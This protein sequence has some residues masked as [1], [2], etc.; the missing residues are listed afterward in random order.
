MHQHH[1][2]FE[3]FTHSVEDSLFLLP[4]LFITYL[5]L[6]FMEKRTEH[7]SLFFSKTKSLLAPFLAAFSGILPQCGVSV[8]G[9]NLYA[10]RVITRGTLITLFL[11]TSDEMLPVLISNSVPTKTIIA[12]ICYKTLIALMA[13]IILDLILKKKNKGQITTFQ[14]HHLCQEAGCNC[15]K[16]N[17]ILSACNHTL[18]IFVFILAINIVLNTLFLFIH[19]EQL[20]THLFNH[21]G[22]GAFFGT[23]FGLIP[24]CATSVISAQLFAEQQIPSG[25]FLSAVLA[26]A[27]VGLIVLFKV[28][29]PH[30][31][32]FKILGVIFLTAFISGLIFNLFNIVF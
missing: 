15:H 20:K 16:K 28:N 31:Q 21:A 10:A 4:Y 26:N 9:T 3:V 6:E 11:A 27:G 2:V 29:R 1:F 32:N 8:A 14:M 17:I 13:G 12:I 30:K 25:T 24:S 18:Q 23:L 22:I 7:I 5:F 19:P